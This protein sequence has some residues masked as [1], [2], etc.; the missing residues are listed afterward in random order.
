[1]RASDACDVHGGAVG[2][3]HADVGGA[4]GADESWVP[5][6]HAWEAHGS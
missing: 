4:K 3:G 5:Y 2:D 6:F 1:M